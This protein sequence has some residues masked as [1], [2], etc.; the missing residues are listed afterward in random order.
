MV[1]RTGDRQIPGYRLAWNSTNDVNAKFQAK[2]MGVIG[3]WPEPRVVL[4]RRKT[5]RRREEASIVAEK[6]SVI[7]RLLFR[8]R[9]VPSFI[10]DNILPAKTLQV[11][12]HPMRVIFELRFSD[13]AAIGIPA[14][15]THRRSRGES[16]ITR[17]PRQ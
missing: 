8:V 2:G 7:L 17:E 11:F 3:K 9:N 13:C 10:D 5:N 15:P 16:S 6:E 12:C 4:G 14:I 1:Q